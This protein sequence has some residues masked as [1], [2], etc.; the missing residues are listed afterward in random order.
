MLVPVRVPTTTFVGT[1]GACVSAQ[2]DVVAVT[3]D[4]GDRLPAASNASTPTWYAVPHERPE[5][6]VLVWAV[7]DTRL[8]PRYPPY[9]TTPVLSLD[10]DH[11]MLRLVGAAVTTRS[12][13]GTVGGDVSLVGGDCVGSTIVTRATIPVPSPDSVVAHFWTPPVR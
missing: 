4:R 1:E 11:D 13:P 9:P 10:G 2:A 3:S 7:V 6:L 8:V 12:D 5:K